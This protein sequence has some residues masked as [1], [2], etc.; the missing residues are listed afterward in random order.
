VVRALCDVKPPYGVRRL[1]QI[2]AAAPA[3]VSRALAFLESEALVTRG[4]RDEVV[5]A[6][7]PALI[8]RWVQ[9]YHFLSSNDAATF[10][11]PRGIPGLIAKL[12]DFRGRYAVTGSL[13][14]ARRASVA[15]ARLAGV[16]VD[17][18]AAVADSLGLRPADAGANVILARPFDA[19]AFTRTWVEDG[20]TFA[21][22]SQ[23]AA[24]LLTSPGRG[25]SEGEELMAWMKSNLDAWRA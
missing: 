14:A 19:V 20:L 25:P 15:A 17:D 6:D 16:Y 5:G 9:D 23:V 22:W 18:P 24:D 11:E 12:R 1:A 10:L 21:A 4:T 8:Q 2:A 7:W 3:S 13:A